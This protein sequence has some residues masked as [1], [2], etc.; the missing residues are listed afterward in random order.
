MILVLFLC[1]KNPM[2]NSC[3]RAK[4]KN[5]IRSFPSIWD[6]WLFIWLLLLLFLSIFVLGPRKISK[7]YG[8][9]SRV[10]VKQ[11]Q[12][13]SL[14]FDWFGIFFFHS[15]FSS[16]SLSVHIGFFEI[17]WLNGINDNHPYSAYFAKNIWLNFKCET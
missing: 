12:Q 15:L 2:E 5:I 10:L 16:L 4:C 13:P 1:L 14:V 17:Y 3:H 7:N 9:W 11:Q 8:P 6:C